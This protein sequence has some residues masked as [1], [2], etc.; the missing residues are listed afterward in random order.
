MDF[1]PNNLSNNNVSQS[2]QLYYV[3]WDFHT[4]TVTCVKDCLLQWATRMAVA[5]SFD[6][7]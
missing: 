1:A 4:S 6:L 5:V 3:A 2:N 7:S